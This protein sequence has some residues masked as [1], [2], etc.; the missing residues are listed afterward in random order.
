MSFRQSGDNCD[1]YTLH[2]E[3]RTESGL[4]KCFWILYDYSIG[5]CIV[6][7]SCSQYF[8]CDKP[9]RMEMGSYSSESPSSSASAEK[10]ARHTVRGRDTFLKE[11]VNLH[12]ENHLQKWK[13]KRFPFKITL[14][15]LLVALV[16]VQVSASSYIRSYIASYGYIRSPIFETILSYT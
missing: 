8:Q 12:F 2:K 5:S 16:T 15:L 11:E 6:S 3:P 9:Q 13:R 1:G 14:H 10:T 4:T 7:L